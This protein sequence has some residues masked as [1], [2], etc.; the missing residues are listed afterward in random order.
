M[1][2]KFKNLKNNLEDLEH[3]GEFDLYEQ[4]NSSSGSSTSKVA[5][6]ILL[7]AFLATLLFYTGSRINFTDL[8]VDPIEGFVDGFNQPSKE[9]LTGMGEM[10][11][12]MGYGTLTREELIDL[13]NEGVTAT[14][15]QNV[16]EAGF[17]NI[18]LDEMVELGNA[19]VSSSFITGIKEVG[20]P[21]ITL[22]EIIALENAG[23]SVTF[24]RMMK[25]LGYELS[26][27][28]LLA[29]EN[30]GV[31]AYFT[32]NMLDLGYTME[33]LSLEN[34][35]RMKNIGVTHQ[36]AESLME[37]RGERLTVDELIRDRISNQ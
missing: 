22:D 31:T 21:D 11:E 32:S 37:E 6:Y 34:L 10:M 3:D 2:S 35:I 19:G 18:T 23:V 20:Y 8:A 26:V 30:A 17:P 27:A 9:I 7:F 4:S 36:R 1:S 14:F 24:T 12:E 29:L 15:T 5:N 25:E 33:E 28:D 16:R 13:R